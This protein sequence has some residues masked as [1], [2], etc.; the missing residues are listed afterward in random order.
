MRRPD[1][2]NEIEMNSSFEHGLGRT[3]LLGGRK[4]RIEAGQLSAFWAAL[5]H[6]VTDYGDEPEYFV[7]DAAAGVVSPV[8]VAGGVCSSQVVARGDRERA[9]DPKRA[10][11]GRAVVRV[12]LGGGSACKPN[13]GLTKAI[14]LEMEARLLRLAMKA[15]GARGA[16]AEATSGDRRRR[17]QQGGADGE[18]WDRAEYTGR[19]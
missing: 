7:S 9:C 15:R 6:Q 14:L 3:Y 10:Q 13:A 5:L 18:S 19:G 4:V 17:L 8:P 1:R 2:H 12:W 16:E 11:S